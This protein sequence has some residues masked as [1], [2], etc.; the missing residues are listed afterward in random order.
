M[1]QQFRILDAE[2][3]KSHP[4]CIALLDLDVRVTSRNRIQ[5]KSRQEAALVLCQSFKLSGH[6]M[7]GLAVGSGDANRLGMRNPWWTGTSSPVTRGATSRCRVIA[8]AMR[9]TMTD[10]CMA[11]R[12]IA[13]GIP[14]DIGRQGCIG[15]VRC[16]IDMTRT[17]VARGR[18]SPG[19]CMAGRRDGSCGTVTGSAGLRIP[20]PGVAHGTVRRGCRRGCRMV[21][22]DPGR[23][24]V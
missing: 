12:A 4:A 24:L 14:G 5:Y 19:P 15:A 22:V 11:E 20:R 1:N 16:A 17:A 13:P 2:A 6:R 10:R 3:N 21:T 18:P 8:F 7:A 23:C 9:S